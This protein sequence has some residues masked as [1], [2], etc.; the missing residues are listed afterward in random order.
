MRESYLFSPYETYGLSW[1]ASR[2]IQNGFRAIR[3][4]TLEKKMHPNL[5]INLEN[6][7]KNFHYALK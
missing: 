7:D 3:V 6:M 2:Y 1:T 4:Y 5:A